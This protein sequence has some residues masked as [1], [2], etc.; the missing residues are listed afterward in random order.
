M[1]SY[2]ELVGVRMGNIGARGLPRARDNHIIRQNNGHQKHNFA[3][4]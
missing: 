3:S 4:M 2:S 1:V